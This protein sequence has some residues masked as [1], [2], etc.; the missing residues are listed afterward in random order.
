LANQQKFPEGAGTSMGKTRAAGFLMSPLGDRMHG[1]PG[2]AGSSVGPT[3]TYHPISHL[4]W[5]CCPVPGILG[6]CPQRSW[7]IWK[8]ALLKEIEEL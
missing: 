2:A 4:E 7:C 3:G 5:G 1:L 6:Q 8:P